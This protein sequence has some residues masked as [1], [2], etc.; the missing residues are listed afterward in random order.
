MGCCVKCA[1]VCVFD[2]C[3]TVCVISSD[4]IKWSCVRFVERSC[5]RVVES[6]HVCER[7][8]QYQSV[9]VRVCKCVRVCARV[10]VCVCAC[11]CVVCV[12]GVFGFSERPSLV[13]HGCVCV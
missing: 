9:H 5:V 4:C 3:A 6:A 1:R 2:V 13:L 11:V 7:A 10:C 12:L 8:C